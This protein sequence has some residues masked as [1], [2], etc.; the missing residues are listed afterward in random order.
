MATPLVVRVTASDASSTP[1]TAKSKGISSTAGNRVVIFM[2][3]VPNGV[4]TIT[5]VG[6]SGYTLLTPPGEVVRLNVGNRQVVGR[7]YEKLSC[8]AN[9]VITVGWSAAVHGDFIAIELSGAHPSIESDCSGS[10][11]YSSAAPT[12]V[13][14]ATTRADV[15][16]IAG[17]ASGNTAAHTAQ[18]G[19]GFILQAAVQ[20]LGSAAADKASGS[21]L[22][23]P[24]SAV[25]EVGTAG[26]DMAGGFARAGV[27]LII[28][29]PGTGAG[30]GGG[31]GV[32][33][34]QAGTDA[35]NSWGMPPTDDGTVHRA[36][37]LHYFGALPS[38][39]VAQD[40]A[41]KFDLVTHNFETSATT[42][43]ITKDSY[44]GYL[45]QMHLVNPQLR[46]GTY[47][48][49]PQI[50]EGASFYPTNYYAHVCPWPTGAKITTFSAS[51]YVAQ[52]TAPSQSAHVDGRGWTSNSFKEQRARDSI[53]KV[54]KCN[55]TQGTVAVPEPLNV[56]S[57][58]SMGTS[59]YKGTQ[60][61][62]YTGSA[63]TQST[64]L[65]EIWK[66]G[67]E[68]RS[69]APAGMPVSINGLIQGTAYWTGATVR[70]LLDHC[71]IGLAEN[72]IRNNFAAFGTFPAELAWQRSMDLVADANQRGKGAWCIVN[73]CNFTA[74]GGTCNYTPAQLEQWV[75]F[76][77]ASYFLSNR[78]FS[79]FEFVSNDQ[80][81]SS[82][83]EAHPYYNLSLGAPFTADT[84]ATTASSA[85]ANILQLKQAGGEY[86]RRYANGVVYVNP[87]TAPHTVTFD[88]AYKTPAGISPAQ[89]FAAGSTLSLAP[90]TGLVLVTQAAVGGNA[91]PP[92]VTITGPATTVKTT[93]VTATATAT[94][95]DGVASMEIEVD[96]SGVWMPMTL[97]GSTW[98]RAGMGLSPGAH[99]FRYRATD[100]NIAPQTSTPVSRT[101]TYVPN[102]EDPTVSFNA[103][104][105][106]VAD[107]NQVVDVSASDPDGVALVELRIAGGPWLPMTPAVA[108][109]YTRSV[110][111]V[112]GAQLLEARAT[113]AHPEPRTSALASRTVTVTVVTPP[114]PPPPAPTPDPGQI[115]NLGAGEW[116]VAVALRGGPVPHTGPGLL[117]ELDWTTIAFDRE[118]GILGGTATVTITGAD[119]LAKCAPLLTELRNWTH[120]LLLYRRDSSS[121]TTRGKLQHVGAV[122]RV[123]INE[124]A[125][126]ATLVSRDLG[127]WLGRRLVRR[128]L[129]YLDPG[130]DARIIAGDAVTEAMRR[131]PSPGL[132]VTGDP[133]GV[134][135][136]RA[137][138]AAQHLYAS[139][140]LE[141]LH[142]AGTRFCVVRRELKV[143]PLHPPRL[144]RL[145][146]DHF[147]DGL[148]TDDDGMAA[149]T[150]WGVRGN[151]GGETDTVWGEATAGAALRTELGLIE[152][153][154]DASEIQVN[155]DADA[156]AAELVR[157]SAIP[158]L[159]LQGGQ[160]K[161]TAPITFDMLEPGNRVG[162]IKSGVRPLVGDQVFAKI[163]VNVTNGGVEKIT[164][165]FGA[166]L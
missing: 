77:I 62:P 58:D 15:L 39:A 73:M 148:G 90:G 140:V 155:S 29:V 11:Q 115:P 100:N 30:G 10:S 118:E 124:K 2:Y 20:S 166:T 18:A 74:G 106:S 98:V 152:Q 101:V 84:P 79:L 127:V 163:S 162:L 17:F 36:S 91:G 126:T 48:K 23:K 110:T 117:G 34:N 139:K 151:G 97:Q 102:A 22:T 46:A 66:I 83:Q 123:T 42:G 6:P 125:G 96:T 40:V 70:G 45:V 41:A 54:T 4:N 164:V 26:V 141:E 111:L 65:Q 31:G 52:P 72:W 13:S 71:D 3:E 134:K 94:D 157:T 75:R 133:T 60:C 81:T 149:A 138:L 130:V 87:T 12:V 107:P 76:S 80:T 28:G 158:P 146:E 122:T 59:S 116:V 56:V 9:E 43:A 121:K 136:A 38:L 114:P 53:H 159:L 67:D 88:R 5:P 68:L 8:A 147:V 89:T 153:V 154:A 160:L 131:D 129:V 156:Y 1:V 51:I 27:G 61:N 103:P 104:A 63:Y 145:L 57:A 112:Q 49:G 144:T 93:V 132:V 32:P 82:W 7:Y 86:R 24:A 78:G 64:W 69:R 99:T 135:V 16:F 137:Y 128:D 113:D 33:G 119:R 143:K 85:G 120:E 161:A 165:D 150:D 55:S 19:L 109:H 105:T 142:S 47:N 92:V 37:N 50:D 108:P 14:T 44:N 25:G 21:L 95:P 35:A